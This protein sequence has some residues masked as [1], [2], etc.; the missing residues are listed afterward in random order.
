MI[1]SQS[2]LGTG[3]LTDRILNTALTA[4]RGSCTCNLGGTLEGKI[5][6]NEGKAGSQQ[7]L[8]IRFRPQAPT[9]KGEP[10]RFQQLQSGFMLA[11][12]V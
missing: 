5:H 6:F 11:T 10:Q 8:L 4:L 7:Q 1:L 9:L 3:L 12:V 2:R